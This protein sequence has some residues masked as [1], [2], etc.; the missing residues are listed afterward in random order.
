L[1]FLKFMA[2]VSN[3]YRPE[4]EGAM[5]GEFVSVCESC[6]KKLAARCACVTGS[7]PSAAEPAGSRRKFAAIGSPRG[8]CVGR[9]PQRCGAIGWRL[10]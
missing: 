7:A 2:D 9:G 3:V 8:L 6:V 10:L 4:L 1:A 5:T